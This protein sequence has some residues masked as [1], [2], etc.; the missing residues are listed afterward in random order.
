MSRS[1]A[2]SV[3]K[4]LDELFRRRN[5]LQGELASLDMTI[6]YIQGLCDEAERAAE[7]EDHEQRMQEA[8][9]EDEDDG[10]PFI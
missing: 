8:A 4:V 1:L 10:L 7:Q 2:D 5:D 9:L 3:R 6:D